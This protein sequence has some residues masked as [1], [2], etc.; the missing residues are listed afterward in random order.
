MLIASLRS[1][2]KK[3]GKRLHALTASVQTMRTA[4][5]GFCLSSISRVCTA[6]AHH[7]WRLSFMGISH[8]WFLVTL[9]E[10][11]GQWDIRAIA[12][13]KMTFRKIAYVKLYL[14]VARDPRVF[15]RVPQ[16]RGGVLHVLGL[17][18]KAMTFM[19]QDSSRCCCAAVSRQAFQRSVSISCV[20]A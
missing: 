9:P 17:P 15:Q 12:R 7:P 20:R 18:L 11:R 5:R 1:C 10:S 19:G 16:E 3:G 4:H 8:E 14:F 13:T 6:L 2:D